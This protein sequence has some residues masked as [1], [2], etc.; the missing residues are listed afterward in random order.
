[1]PSPASA[2]TA[3][4]ATRRNRRT[5]WLILAL[6]AM[7]L[8]ASYAAFYLWQPSG[9][10]NY[11][12]L[13]APAP[14]PDSALV[15]PA[16]A[17]FRLSEAKGQW[18]LVKAAPGACDE[19]CVRDLVY[20]RQVRLAQGKETARVR[21]VWLVSDGAQPD[22]ALLA[23]HPDLEVARNA[24]AVIGALPA[25]RSALEHVYVIDPLGNVMMR[26]PADPDPR[27]MLKDLSR[28]LRHSKWK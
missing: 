9:Q 21:T 27:K 5:L 4:P 11:G 2:E 22:P 15:T 24:G 25:P 3:S 19:R 18:V 16:G 26:F 7:P 10:L 17:P 12:E 20:L 1:M 23:Q 13:I 14:L 6:C 28:L 8:I